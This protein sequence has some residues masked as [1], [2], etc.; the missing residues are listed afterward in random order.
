[1]QG[2]KDDTLTAISE[3]QLAERTIVICTM[4]QSFPRKIYLCGVC[5]R[6]LVRC[7]AASAKLFVFKC[8]CGALN[9]LR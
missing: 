5:E 9:E 8:P 3:D 6:A 4:P 7:E 1:M 2:L